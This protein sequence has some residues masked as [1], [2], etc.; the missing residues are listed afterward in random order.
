MYGNK[1]K[2]VHG[3]L[4]RVIRCQWV[5]F[6]HVFSSFRTISILISAVLY[7]H[8][9]AAYNSLCN[10]VMDL[11]ILQNLFLVRIK[12]HFI[13]L[14]TLI[15]LHTSIPSTQYLIHSTDTNNIKSRIWIKSIWQQTIDNT[16]SVIRN[17]IKLTNNI[18]CSFNLILQIRDEKTNPS[19]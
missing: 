15:K 14:Y 8:S 4:K 19:Q 17:E 6:F 9:V 18:K 3:T 10:I 5:L 1:N 12:K 13:Y 11:I 7:S 16:K 2:N